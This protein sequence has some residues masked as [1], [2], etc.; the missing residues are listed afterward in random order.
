MEY[1]GNRCFSSVL[2]SRAYNRIPSN[3][4][5]LDLWRLWKSSVV[6]LV[7][8][9]GVWCFVG[10]WNGICD[11]NLIKKDVNICLRI[12]HAGLATHTRGASYSRGGILP[13]VTVLSGNM[14]P[15]GF[16]EEQRNPDL[17]QFT[18][19]EAEP[20][21]KRVKKISWTAYPMVLKDP[22]EKLMIDER[23]KTLCL[24]KKSL[25]EKLWTQRIL[26]GLNMCD[27]TWQHVTREKVG[28]TR[29]TQPNSH[30]Q[31]SFI[32]FQTSGAILA[33][34]MNS[35]GIWVRFC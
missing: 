5:T 21:A 3:F 2:K 14:I 28:L 18:D 29:F 27:W 6:M 19:L 34:N 32:I 17:A 23:N 15:F 16:E 33:W 20:P 8:Q 9:D 10:I 30:H 4:D 12:P 35:L 31:R 13:N 22:R 24:F 7:V 1:G 11:P 26:A 25:L